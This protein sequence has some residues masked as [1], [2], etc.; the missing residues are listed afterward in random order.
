MKTTG[1]KMILLV[2]RCVSE[3][4]WKKTCRLPKIEL[5]LKLEKVFLLWTI[6]F[7]KIP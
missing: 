4:P 3:M 1:I 5:T 6:L 2:A 7:F